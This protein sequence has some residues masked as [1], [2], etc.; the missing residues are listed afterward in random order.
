[1]RQHSVARKHAHRAHYHGHSLVRLM[2]AHAADLPALHRLLLDLNADVW[3]ESPAHVDVRAADAEA[4]TEALRQSLSVG[5]HAETIVADVEKQLLA[6]YWRA[7]DKRADA[8]S[9]PSV[10][11]QLH[12]PKS[13]FAEYH[14]L[15]EIYEW[16]QLLTV[17]H[18]DRITI[19][20][21]V[22]FSHEGR[23]LMAV[24][25]TNH[26][27]T[28]ATQIK[29]QIY[30]QGGIHA[31]EW[32]SHSTAQ[33]I[34]YHLAT[35]NDTAITTL[36]DEAEVVLV[37]VVNP[38][39]YAYTWTTD[40]IWRKNRRNNGHGAFGVDLNRNYPAHWGEG[41]SFTNPFVDK[42]MGPSAGSEPELQALM[43][44][45]DS[46]PRVVAALDLHSFS[47]VI[48]RPLGWTGED[49]VHES[50]HKT[51]GDA[52]ARI[53]KSV[54]GKDYV[55]EKLF[56]FVL[57]SGTATDWFY[58]QSRP[59]TNLFGAADGKSNDVATM[60]KMALPPEHATVFRP[61]SFTLELR[62][63]HPGFGDGFFDGF[64]LDPSEIVPV[65]EEVLPAFL[66]FARFAMENVLTEVR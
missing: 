63:L 25:F 2:P 58:M 31:R 36:L 65:G 48:L 33:Y 10:A 6:P 44:F 20:R 18:K 23:E 9:R 22:G 40:R 52:M 35:S 1:M 47:Q 42:Y 61:Y 4:L 45:F 37:P 50:Q 5:V 54:H 17:T 53:I 3:A 51:V 29:K 39:G 55:S 28:K 27:S 56:D 11:A 57:T 38:D 21:N 62:P 41:G 15:N 66:H 49:A 24:R 7:I 59:L 19:T 13:W 43:A 26:A 32:I 46:L 64:M 14:D 34:A 8:T 16:Y 60:K 12:D 30:V